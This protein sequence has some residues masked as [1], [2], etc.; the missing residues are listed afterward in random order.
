MCSAGLK[1][2][3]M[4]IALLFAGVVLFLTGGRV[5]AGP[6]D[7]TVAEMRCEQ[8]LNPLGVDVPRPRLSWVLQSRERGQA[9]MAYQ[10]L[11]ASTAAL[12][13]QD[14]ADLWNSGQIASDD[15]QGILY[16]GQTLRSSQQ[17]FWKV[18]VWD[19]HGNPS[20]W[21]QVA[22]WT[23][24]VPE[25]AG[26]P[27]PEGPGA[28]GWSAR[29]ITDPEL[30][31]WRRPLL[32]YHSE[33]TSDPGTRK[34]VQLDLGV[35][36]TLEAVRL[37][38]MRHTVIEA[39]GFPRRF[40]LE[41][42]DDPAFR[43]SSVI[44]DCGEKDYPD[45]WAVHL[46]VPAAGVTARYVR[47][48]ATRLRVEE[49]RAC[50]AFSQIEVIAGGH[51]VAVGAAVTA[52]DS[53]ERA[54]W[55][56]GALADGLGVPGANPR[57]N[58]T[59]LLRR[60][61]SVRPGLRRALAQVCG[62]GQY[63]LT[64]NGARAGDRQFAPGW[65]NYEK[66]CLYDT[67]DV[68]AL[69]HPGA[70]AAGLFLAGGMY[71]VQEG[72]YVKFV[73]PPRPLA[74][75]AEL[76]LEYADGTVE[77]FGTDDRWRV[78]PGPVTF[79]N[80]FGGEDYDA[81][82]EPAGW[83]ASGYD[84][85]QWARAV[86][87]EG[88]G[89]KLRGHSFAGP[90]IRT[91]EVLRPVAT[92]ALRPGVTVFDLGQNAAL[93]PR[94]KVHGPAGAVVRIIPAELVAPD[95]SVDRQSC[96]GTAWWQYT[97]K[98]GGAEEWFPKFFYHGCRYL[99]IECTA[100]AADQPVVDS[101]EGVVVQ[102]AAAAAGEFACSN[103][104]FN[105]IHTLVRW[106]Q[107]S[108]MMSVLTDCPH[109]ERLGWIEQNHLNGPALRYEFDLG[110]LLAKTVND[111]A[112]S[113]RADGLVPDIAPEYVMFSGGFRDSPEWGSACLLVPWQQYEWTGDAELLRRSYE[114]MKRYVAY[115]G[116]RASDHLVAF[117]LGD[118]YDIGPYPPGHAQLTPR[119]LTA[120]AFY[121]YDAWILAQTATL[122]GK[123]GEAAEYQE[124]AG[125]IRAAFNRA[126]F[127][128]ATGRYATGSQSANAIPLVMN[129]VE[130]D[131]RQDVLDAIVKDV[132][133]RGNA[134]TA[135]D[136]GY[137]YLL[138]ALADGGRS[139]VIFDMNNQSE[140]PGYGYQLTQGATSLT[141]AWNADRR[142]S[143]NHFMLGQINEW[144]YHDLAGIQ[145]DPAGPGFKKIVI[146]PALT[147]GL[148]WVE[149]GYRSARGRIASAWRLAGSRVTLAVAVPPG[150]TATVWVPTADATSVRE[151][152]RPAAQ[153][154]GVQW[155]RAESGAA[156]YE[157]TSGEFVFSATAPPER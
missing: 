48:T 17:V 72:R 146:R 8:D 73:S 132:R 4:K 75:I 140:K 76:R 81:R 104:L 38:A 82:R 143:Q 99:Q 23:M 16:N 54:P 137:R 57:A 115:L 157:V 151:G 12:L 45:R 58:A 116:S 130:P 108:N 7:L 6:Q 102:A 95:G 22:T 107:R 67:L 128:P 84:D 19:R 30:L 118:W 56:A 49:N 11:V 105:R 144:F 25:A 147:G 142:S 133:R 35:S 139:D 89:G 126:F 124:L 37:H 93:M 13:A 29:W 61:F 39:T 96:G 65:T 14:Q 111:M 63:E 27:T 53:W 114:M 5:F 92:R 123:P 85:S 59:L 55:S 21:S 2:D 15:A 135:G 138:R 42:S 154:P 119:A 103:E 46:E 78:A 125:L 70:N 68:T 3:P 28:P 148:S 156:I 127:N 1:K 24:G 43:D 136:V 31:R 79:A 94:L 62:L 71:N 40:K 141:E 113:Q 10:V 152:G 98:G 131:H 97:L 50:L 69:L 88:P 129:L 80:I 91:F 112:D 41:A 20:A 9:Q 66:T 64:L 47:L 83:N 34:W 109:R 117:G 36:R 101:L 110:R 52:S 120:T 150:T 145:G 32:G 155:V 18:R 149:A 134:L 60:E 26:L 90:P 51:N 122:V 100:P 74:A 106:A 86:E 87:F 121:Y 33:E 153:S 77:I 44:F